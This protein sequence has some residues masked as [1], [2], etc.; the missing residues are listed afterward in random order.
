[1]EEITGEGLDVLAPDCGASIL[2]AEEDY[3]MF[4]DLE[5]FLENNQ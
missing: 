4:E 1:M 3:P 2:Q 5:I